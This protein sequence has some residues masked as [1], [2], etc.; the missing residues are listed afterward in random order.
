MPED[1]LSEER[2]NRELADELTAEQAHDRRWA[3]TVLESAQALLEVEFRKAGKQELY[4]ALKVFLSARKPGESYG[5]VAQ[6]L[7]TTEDAIRCAV[8]RLRRRYGELIREEVAQ[9]LAS[10]TK[11]QVDDEVRHLLSVVGS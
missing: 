6:K 11:S 10:P 3:M 9:T 8:Q 2:F 7:A 1:N 5:Q 4:N